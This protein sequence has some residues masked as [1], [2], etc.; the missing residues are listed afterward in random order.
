MHPTV[1]VGWTLNYEM[2]FYVLFAAGML[3]PSR[4]AGL[5]ATGVLMVAAVV[6]GLLLK[7]ADAV[8]SFYAQPLVLEFVGGMALGV[9]LFRLPADRRW[10]WPAVAIGVAA[11]VVMLADGWLFP[12][13]DRSLI[14][15]APAVVVVAAAVV[16]ERAGL[17]AGQG[18]VQLLGAASY[19]VYLTHFFAT[20][21]VVKVFEYCHAAG[22]LALL[23][24]PLA[25]VLVVLIGV[26]AHLKLELPLTEVARRCLAPKRARR[27][28]AS[29]IA[30][31]PAP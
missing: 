27:E 30:A 15:G 23:G 2:M 11:F 16:A 6:A 14:F 12:D 20:Q 17:K 10:A 22:P 29:K 28:P 19:A 25:F 18:W 31:E 7:P 4:I 9:L 5:A 8:L 1:F 3:L 24:A 13:A 21:A 26:L